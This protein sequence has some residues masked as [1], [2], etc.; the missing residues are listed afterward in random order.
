MATY[1]KYL[2]FKAK[3]PWYKKILFP[4]FLNKE[5]YSEY[6]KIVTDE[7]TDLDFARDWYFYYWNEYMKKPNYY[8]K[9]MM[10]Y[11]RSVVYDLMRFKYES[12]HIG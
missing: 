4:L 12:N 3:L 7:K 11:Y 9:N 1:L 2:S 5:E 10:E 6:I 8:D